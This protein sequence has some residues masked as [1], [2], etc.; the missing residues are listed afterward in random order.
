V[1]ERP[2]LVTGGAEFT[3]SKFSN[4]LNYQGNLVVTP[5]VRTYAGRRENLS[6]HRSHSRYEFVESSIADKDTRPHA[7]KKSPGDKAELT[8]MPFRR[9]QSRYLPADTVNTC[10][11]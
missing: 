9:W 5:V 10:S 2:I 1:N 8:T 3:G 6:A 7:S 4:H 11:N